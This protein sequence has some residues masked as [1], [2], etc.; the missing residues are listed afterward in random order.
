MS[1]LYLNAYTKKVSN[2]YR[3][4]RILVIVSNFNRVLQSQNSVM[5]IWLYGT[6]TLNFI[7]TY[8]FKMVLRVFTIFFPSVLFSQPDEKNA[9]IEKSNSTIRKYSE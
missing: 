8:Q 3:I 9:V 5:N 1:Q 4:Y 2:S 6:S 7:L